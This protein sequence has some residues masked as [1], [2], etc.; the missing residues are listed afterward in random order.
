MT[1]YVFVT[2]S[3]DY[4][5][6]FEIG[7]CFAIE[8]TEFEENLKIINIG[9]VQGVLEDK[10]L[11]FGS[12]EYL[13]FESYNDFIQGV[14][15]KPCSEEFYKEWASLTNGA[16]VGFDVMEYLLDLCPESDE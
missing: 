12:N 1:D 14:R 2:V 7:C 3:H 9:F 15:S 8:A 5:D 11:Y 16:A 10:D 4:A 6:E 13:S